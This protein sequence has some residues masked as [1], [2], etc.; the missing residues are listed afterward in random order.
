MSYN[1][2]ISENRNY[3]ICR[4]T[5]TMT[6]RTAKEFAKKMDSL[7]RAKNI[8]RFLI[9]AREAPN[10]STTYQNY[11]FAYKDM[12]DLNLQRDVRS[13]ILADPADFSHDFP[14]MAQQNAWFNVRIFH[15][16]DAALAWLND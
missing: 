15:D 4:V 14:I 8:K 3:I 1:I 12:N 11:K 2:T 5:G 9:D 16:E 7:S 13:A 6:V 10:I